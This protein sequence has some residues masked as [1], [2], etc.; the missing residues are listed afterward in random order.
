MKY[1]NYL[2]DDE[3]S[4]GF[5]TE[6]N[7]Y[8]IRTKKIYGYIYRGDIHKNIVLGKEPK[9]YGSFK[10]SN[11]YLVLNENN[12]IKRYTTIKELTLLDVSNID[13]NHENLLNFFEKEFIKLNSENYIEKIVMIYLLQL[14]YGIILNNKIKSYDLKYSV[15]I[16]YFKKNGITDD[17]IK[18]SFIVSKMYE[19]DKTILPSRFGLRPFDKLL[20][21]LLKKYLYSFKIDG[22][23]YI[24][25]EKIDDKNLLCNKFSETLC[26]PTEICIFHPNLDL[27]GIEIWKVVNGKLIKIK[28]NFKR[29]IKKYYK[30]M[31]VYD[32]YRESIKNKYEN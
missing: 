30:K 11:E 28:H 25:N 16:D 10:S 5:N 19:N 20:V 6:F 29:N 2:T 3:F 31:S 23:L 17:N 8:T 7:N 12:Y 22:I 24:K 14:C 1:I 13:N 4:K 15:F 32:L 18:T 21:K 26:A 9:F 27:G